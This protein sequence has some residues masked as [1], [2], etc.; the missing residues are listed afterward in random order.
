M[1]TLLYRMEDITLV[2]VDLALARS[3]D[4]MANISVHRLI[5]TEFRLYMNRQTQCNRWREAATILHVA[6]PQQRKGFALFNQWRLCESLI[7]HVQILAER[8]IWL[9]E[10]SPV[11]YLED[12]VFLVSDASR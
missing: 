1:L 12:F 8:Y 5:Q 7:E 10:L 4:A 11:E 9:D 3:T 6:F 2:F